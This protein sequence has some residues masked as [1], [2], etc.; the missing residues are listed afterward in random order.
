MAICKNIRATKRGICIGDLDRKG[1]I[2]SR[3][4][5]APESGV[6]FAE[7]FTNIATVWCLFR[8]VEGLEFFD[9]TGLNTTHTH[10]AIFRYS[11]IFSVTSENWFLINNNRYK[12]LRVENLDERNEWIL[13]KMIKK[14]DKD[15]NA[16]RV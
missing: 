10:E 12:I 11:S 7:D 14:G 4:M 8:T 2:Q 13:T 6:D 1:T 3:T 9:D 16:N 5:Q 15:I